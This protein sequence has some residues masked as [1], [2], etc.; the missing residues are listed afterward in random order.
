MSAGVCGYTCRV[1]VVPRGTPVAW[2]ATLTAAPLLIVTSGSTNDPDGF[3]GT[4][5]PLIEVTRTD[6]NGFSVDGSTG[7]P[8][9]ELMPPASSWRLDDIEN[10]SRR[11]QP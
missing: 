7:D 6:A 4:A 5:T 2:I 3:G 11:T 1:T 9:V 10:P 8:R